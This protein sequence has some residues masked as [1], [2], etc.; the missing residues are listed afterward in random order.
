MSDEQLHTQTAT[1]SSSLKVSIGVSAGF[2]FFGL[3]EKAEVIGSATW[4][5]T[6]STGT[7]YGSVQKAKVE[8]NTTTVGFHDVIDVYED[9]IYH[10]F[11]FV[12]ET[13]GTGLPASSA[14]ASGT[15]RNAAG[16]ALARQLVTVTF[17]DGRSRR[18]FTDARGTYRVFRAPAGALRIASGDAVT[19]ATVVAGR[20]IVQHLTL[21]GGVSP[22]A[23]P[24][25]K[26]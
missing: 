13:Q 24:A 18:V 1:S 22:R 3:G 5:N 19:Q 20:P 23:V 26:R 16:Q 7:S 21:R 12:S 8:L 6:S 4:T 25:I 15:I 10:T 9:S 11:A 17:A 2:S 14:A